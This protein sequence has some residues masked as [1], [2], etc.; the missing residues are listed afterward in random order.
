MF[1]EWGAGMMPVKDCIDYATLGAN[2]PN[3]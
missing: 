2:N 1:D 3:V